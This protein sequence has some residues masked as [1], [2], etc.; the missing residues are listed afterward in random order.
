MRFWVLFT[1][2]ECSQFCGLFSFGLIGTG[3]AA[4]SHSIPGGDSR[5][6]SPQ[7]A[8]AEAHTRLPFSKAASSPT[9]RVR[10]V[11]PASN[12]LTLHLPLAPRDRTADKGGQNA[13]VRTPRAAR[14][15]ALQ[16]PTSS[17]CDG[18]PWNVEPWATLP[19]LELPN[20]SVFHVEVKT[21]NSWA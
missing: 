4:S 7:P 13:A 12:R 3:P 18:G 2:S 20:R 15:H 1:L 14:F 19:S 11:L 10:T 8:R 17:C 5:H 21:E 9:P 6:V 16:L